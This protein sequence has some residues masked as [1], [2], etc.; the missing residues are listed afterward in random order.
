M[1]VVVC[2]LYI[3]CD[4]KITCL[5]YWVIDQSSAVVKINI[6][7][8]VEEPCILWFENDLSCLWTCLKVQVQFSTFV[9]NWFDLPIN[10]PLRTAT[11]FKFCWKLVWSSFEL[12]LE[13]NLTLISPWRTCIA[14]ETSC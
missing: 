6:S 14:K 13:Y 11:F 8:F 7:F 5:T 3:T 4:Y 1:W 10:I 2:V 12:A 9:E